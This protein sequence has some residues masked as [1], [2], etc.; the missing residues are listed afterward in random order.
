MTIKHIDPRDP[1]QR[2]MDLSKVRNCQPS[3]IEH[4]RGARYY[5]RYW[6]STLNR[7]RLSLALWSLLSSLEMSIEYCSNS[8]RE[9]W[10]TGKMTKR[11][12]RHSI[13]ES[14]VE[15]V[16]P[17]DNM[18]FLWTSPQPLCR[19]LVARM[20]GFLYSARCSGPGGGGWPSVP[21]HSNVL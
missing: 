13:S 19:N 8:Q 11:N 20:G 18:Y 10:V 16:G 3:F 12:F 6:G 2:P 17:V 15:M 9:G 7:P 1:P 5:A 21:V 14:G 4:V